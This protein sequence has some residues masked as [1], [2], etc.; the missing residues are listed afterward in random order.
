MC[1]IRDLGEGG[2][3]GPNDPLGLQGTSKVTTEVREVKESKRQTKAAR[4]FDDLV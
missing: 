4:A 2:V 3:S 1:L